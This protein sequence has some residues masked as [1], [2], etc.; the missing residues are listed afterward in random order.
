[1]SHN[2]EK[3]FQAHGALRPPGPIG[4]LVKLV[5]AG[6]Y[7]YY[8]WQLVSLW[9]FL[10]DADIL[11]F[12]ASICLPILFTLYLALYLAPYVI[13]I[14]WRI[15]TKRIS[16]FVIFL[17]SIGLIALSYFISQNLNSYALNLFTIIWVVYIFTHLGISFLVAVITSTPGC[18]MRALPH[19]WSV[20]NRYKTYERVCHGPLHKINPWEQK[21]NEQ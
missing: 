12:N 14:G 5:F 3:N 13:N 8:V 11:F 1:M 15:N 16:Q 10:V 2:T 6:S 17:V 9:S 4:R 18:E 7:L 20:F 19:L 21:F